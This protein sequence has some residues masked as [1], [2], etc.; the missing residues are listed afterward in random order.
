MWGSGLRVGEEG[1]RTLPPYPGP[2]DE[3]ACDSGQ[4]GVPLWP[5]F[6]PEEHDKVG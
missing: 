2:S 4:V 5:Q 6:S 3:L 1:K